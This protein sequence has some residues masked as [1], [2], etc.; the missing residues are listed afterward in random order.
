MVRMIMATLTGTGMT[1]T[2]TTA[3]TSIL[4]TA[5]QGSK[6]RG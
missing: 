6:L 1:T 3:M 2:I 4:A 5:L